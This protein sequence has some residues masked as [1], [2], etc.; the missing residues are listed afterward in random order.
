[1]EFSNK[2][3]ALLL[4][5]AMVVSLGG[6]IISLNRLNEV[7][8]VGYATTATGTVQLNVQQALSITTTDGNSV[9]FKQCTPS[10]GAGVTTNVTTDSLEQTGTGCPYYAGANVSN[11]SV[12]NDGNVNATVT[13]NSSV[14]GKADNGTG[15]F[16]S[17]SAATSSLQYKIT[18]AGRGTNTGGCTSIGNASGAYS[19]F[20]S[21][22]YGYYVCYNLKVAAVGGA[23]SF[24]THYKIVMPNDAPTGTSTANIG[25]YATV[26]ATP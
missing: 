16:L 17:S 9:D 14:V 8:T 7:Q 3:L 5:A 11:I 2:A 13:I 18:S 19:A 12:R 1:M 10:T 22:S 26:S 24:V 4:L 21:P 6:T 23:N 20:A 25:Y 15:T